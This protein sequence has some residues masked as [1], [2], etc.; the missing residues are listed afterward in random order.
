MPSNLESLEVL[1]L[2]K[3]LNYVNK[4]P[5]NLNNKLQDNIIETKNQ[6]ELEYR[7]DYNNAILY[8]SNDTK[9]KKGKGELTIYIF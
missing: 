5:F 4:Y 2:F 7:K 9:N 3:S 1:D 6:I 8:N